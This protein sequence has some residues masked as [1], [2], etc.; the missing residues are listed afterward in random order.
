M[1]HAPVTQKKR[2]RCKGLASIYC[3]DYDSVS[4]I[5]N[6]FDENCEESAP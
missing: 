3:I 4:S 1:K 5:E 2:K 6:M